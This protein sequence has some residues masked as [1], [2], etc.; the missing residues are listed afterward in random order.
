MKSLKLLLALSAVAAGIGSAPPAL[1][2]S[3]D[4]A[5]LASLQAAGITYQGT[6]R[7]IAAGKAVCKMAGQGKPM[8][9]VVKTVQSLNPGLHGDNAAR[10]TAIAANVYCPQTLSVPTGG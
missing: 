8:A 10:F 6:D 2:D 1:A 9:D 5:F 4:D 3:S 7:V